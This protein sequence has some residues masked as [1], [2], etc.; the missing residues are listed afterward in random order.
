MPELLRSK[1]ALEECSFDP[2]SL[3]RIL[4]CDWVACDAEAGF[5]L[6]LLEPIDGLKK[7]ERALDSPVPMTVEEAAA[8]LAV[9]GSDSSIDV[10][11]ARSNGPPKAGGLAAASALAAVDNDR[12]A[13]AAKHWQRR[14]DGYENPEGSLVEIYGTKRRVWTVEEMERQS[15]RTLVAECVK[16]FREDYGPLLKTWNP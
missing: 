13:Q 14:F 3:A 7:L 8:Y 5:L 2:K 15:V 11:I 10:L 1:N 4:K 9:I 6:Y 16:R 12:A